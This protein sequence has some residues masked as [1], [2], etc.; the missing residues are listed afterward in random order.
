MRKIILKTL[1]KVGVVIVCLSVFTCQPNQ[2]LSRQHEGVFFID[3]DLSQELEILSSEIFKSVKTII[4]ET[5]N[6]SLIAHISEM[7]VFENR[8][9]ILDVIGR[10]LL[11]FDT[12]GRFIRR[13]G[14]LGRGPG[15]YR[16]ISDF[17]IDPVN[18][19]ILVAADGTIIQYNTDGEFI[20]SVRPENGIHFSF[21]QYFD[22]KIFVANRQPKENEN[23]LYLIDVDTGKILD[24][25][26]DLEEDNLGWDGWTSSL[27]FFSRLYGTP[28]YMRKFMNVVWTLDDMTPYI[29]FPSENFP[30]KSQLEEIKKLDIVEQSSRISLLPK[31]SALT[32]FMETESTIMFTY[33]KSL[34]YNNLL[35]KKEEGKFFNVTFTNDLLHNGGHIHFLKCRDEKGNFYEFIGMEEFVHYRD[36]LVNDLD[37]REQLLTLSDEANPIIFYYEVND[38]K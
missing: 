14:G 28:K 34:Q 20:K 13:I 16:N 26:F 35:Y 7:Q 12:E 8:I 36:A 38:A 10:A 3:I 6:E 23:L 31:I 18:S 1:K 25:F 27:V 2:K 19:R 15:E 17:T 22:E 4:L 30:N 5:R 33:L 24:G 9:F 37:K 11:V 32:S 21:I 29:T